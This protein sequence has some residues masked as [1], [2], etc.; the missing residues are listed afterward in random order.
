MWHKCEKCFM[1]RSAFEKMFS[2]KYI[3]LYWEN[4]NRCRVNSL[5][6][7]NEKLKK[8]PCRQPQWRRGVATRSPFVLVGLVMWP[9][10]AYCGGRM[11]NPTRSKWLHNYYIYIFFNNKLALSLL[12]FST[13]FVKIFLQG[14]KSFIISNLCFASIVNVFKKMCF[15][16][17]NRKHLAIS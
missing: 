11:T 1:V 12:K 9:T 8:W 5:F 10:L 2:I 15:Q 16:T 4:P 3:Y 17:E 14:V 13:C 7:K 6:I